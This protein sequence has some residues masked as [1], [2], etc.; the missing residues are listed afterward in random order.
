[1]TCASCS[2]AATDGCTICRPCRKR[3]TKNAN[4]RYHR[5]RAEGLC[6]YCTRPSLHYTLCAGCREEF[7]FRQRL[8]Y[9][10]RKEESA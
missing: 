6:A 3:A 9:H 4:L 1:M 10:R 8:N 2:R 7:N 5:L